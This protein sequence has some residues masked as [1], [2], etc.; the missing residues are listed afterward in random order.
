MGIAFG[1]IYTFFGLAGF[2]AYDALIPK[3]V[4][5][6]WSN[7]LYGSTSIGFSVLLFF[8]GRQAFQNNDKELMKTLLYGIYAWLSVEAAFSIYYSAYFNIGVDILLATVLGY[9]LIKSIQTWDQKK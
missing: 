1:V 9:P 8:V 4:I 3:D 7:G 5:T 2:P 6:S